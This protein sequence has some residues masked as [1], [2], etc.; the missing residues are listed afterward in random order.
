[1]FPYKFFTFSDMDTI[2]L[3]LGDKGLDPVIGAAEL[4]D[5]FARCAGDIL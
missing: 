4:A 1:V 2:E 3:I 5:Y